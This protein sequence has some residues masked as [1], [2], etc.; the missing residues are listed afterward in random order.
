MD[1]HTIF[2]LILALL[3]FVVGPIAL[4][5]ALANGSWR[6]AGDQRRRSGGGISSM[7][8]GAMLEMDHFVRPSVEH[9]IETQHRV[10]KRED[11]AD[12]E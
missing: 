1:F 8:G 2:Y 12:G 10:L 9:R 3:T 11:D 7:I 5:W 4:I 6:K